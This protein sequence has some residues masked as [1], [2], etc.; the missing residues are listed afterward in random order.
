MAT[1]LKERIDNETT[2]REFMQEI[3]N[4]KNVENI[5]LYLADEYVIFIDNA[6]PW[7]GKTL[8]RKDFVTRLNYT[9]DS[10]PDI[11]F[12]I[13]TAVS[14]ADLV[15]ITWVMTG[16]NTGKIAGFP[17]TN[18][19]IAANGVTFYHFSDGKI[20][21]HTQVYDRTTI[22]RQLGFIA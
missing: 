2:L 3:W 20:C 6:D 4:E 12:E 17:A 18:R 22:I 1:A 7:E 10:F 19:K 5:S 9:F 8:S 13:K 16:T 21:G 11:H 14:D 15:A